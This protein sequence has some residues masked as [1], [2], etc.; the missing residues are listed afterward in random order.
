MLAATSFV[1]ASADD[2][3]V[4]LISPAI[5]QSGQVRRASTINITLELVDQV[6]AYLQLVRIDSPDMPF[7]SEEALAAINAMAS[8]APTAWSSEVS[9]ASA[10]PAPQINL[11]ELYKPAMS[12]A[13]LKQVYVAQGD[14]VIAS[15]SAYVKAYHEA[16]TIYEASELKQ[17]IDERR[18]LDNGLDDLYSARNEYEKQAIL[19]FILQNKYNSRFRYSVIS[20]VPVAQDGP[21][22]YFN[23]AVTNLA[24]AKYEVIVRDSK[25]EYLL[26]P[27]RR[28][29]VV[30]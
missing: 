9:D 20:Q 25:T 4:K 14:L 3:V 12:D 15:N 5:D 23:Y 17:I 26:M 28:F 27:K 7:V 18:L 2:S 19:F 29:V 16:R 10:D 30:E 11:A 24:P 1:Y 22:P 8:R 6:D 13:E 21:L